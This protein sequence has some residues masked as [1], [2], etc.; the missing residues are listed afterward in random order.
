MNGGRAA[1]PSVPGL[2][3]VRLLGRGQMADVH[4]AREPELGR[5]VALKVLRPDASSADPA[6]RARFER[7]ARALA[8]LSHPNVVQVHRYGHTDDGRPY[9]V[10]QYVKGRSVADRLEAGGPL[11]AA[12]ARQV[13]TAVAEALEAAHRHGIVHRDVRPA[14]VL[15]EEETGRV[16]LTDF[17]IAREIASGEGDPRRLTATGQVIGDPRF[18][19]PEELR[20]EELTEQVDVYGLAVLGYELLTGRG[21]YGDAS[22]P[23]LAVAHLEGE[24]ADL[25]VEHGVEPP[26]A[27]LLLRC[28]AKNPASRP[29]TRDVVRALRGEDSAASEGPWQALT[30]RLF[31]RRRIPYF[32]ALVGG[33]GIGLVDLVEMLQDNGWLPDGAFSVTL[34]SVLFAVPAAIVIAWF[35]GERGR[36]RVPALEIWIL[37]ALAVGWAAAVAAV[38]LG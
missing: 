18:R 20:G 12:E 29:T 34:V 14:N 9:L 24:P 7:E 35:H 6:A 22:G 32:V 23:A 30:R 17:G 5:L 10:M 2:E 16:L 31:G 33:A 27:R 11:P 3:V 25:A 4:L 28:L 21:P 8:A 38:L 13:L 26:L 19:S 1:P 37:A 36:Q 15:L